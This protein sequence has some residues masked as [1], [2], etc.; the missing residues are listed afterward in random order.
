MSGQAADNRLLA[1]F[2][3]HPTAANLL[4]L[5]FLF[6]G[7]ISVG[8]ILRETFPDYSSSEVQISV[9]Y[10]GATAEEVEEAVCRRI[11]DAVDSVT[12]VSEVE[13][14]AR[15]GLAQVVV[16][17]SGQG[18]MTSFLNDIK[19]EVEAITDFPD[20][21]EAPTVKQ[22]N[23]TDLVCAVA[24]SGPMSVTD[25]ELYCEQLKKRMLRIPEVSQI[26]IEGFSD[27][28]LRVEVPVSALR[29]FGVSINDVADAI[30]RQSVNL[31]AGTLETSGRDV[32]VR[33]NDERGTVQGLEDLLV[34]SSGSGAELTLGDF[35]TITDS[36]ELDEDKI[37]FNGKR[38]G[39]LKINKIK[40]EDALD[41]MDQLRTFLDAERRAA[42]PGV[43]LTVTQNVSE[44]VRDRLSLLLLNGEQGFA[45]VF[46]V[47]WAFFSFR[48]SF[49][50]AM[51]MPASFAGA[52]FFM[53]QFGFS[54]NMLSMVGLLLALGL[55]MDDAIVI[56]ENVATHLQRGAS[57]LEAAVRGTSE[58]A[59][60]V[61]S[62][63]LTTVFIFGS[64]AVFIAGD[65]GKVLWVMPVVLLLTL[66][67]SLV[68]AFL[69]LPN[70][71]AH[72]LRAVQGKAPGRFRAWFDR[73]LDWARDRALGAVVDWAMSWR[74]LFVGLVIAVFLVS[75][76]MLAGGVLKTQ[77][78]P[79]VDGDVLMARI[80]LPQGTPLS[81]TENVVKLVTDALERVDKEFTPRQPKVDGKPS[82]LVK[83][84][85][86]QFNANP[87]AN[88]SG[89]HLAVVIADL[90][91]AQDRNARLDAVAELWRKEVGNV[92]DVINITYKQPQIGP[93]G[94]AID[95]RLQGEDLQRLKAASLELADW[96]GQYKGVKDLSDDL[97][98]GKPE[99]D[100]RVKE[101]ALALGLDAQTIAAQ[102]RGALYGK[103]A[104]EVQR[105]D[106]SYE[107]VVQ[108]ADEDQNSVAD[109]EYFHITTSED[110]LV[111]LYTVAEAAHT[112]GWARIAHV[113]GQ[114][115]VTIKGDVDTRQGNAD[116]IMAD[117]RQRFL[118]ELQ[119]RYPDLRISLEGQAKESA[120]T[121]GSLRKALLVGIFGIFVLLSFQFK[122]YI[123]PLVVIV[124]IP[125]A[126]IGVIWGHLLMGYP[127]TMPGI[128]GYVSL[129]GVVVNDS[130]LLVQFIKLRMGEGLDVSDAAR[131]ASRQRFRAIML[132]SLTTIAGLF[133]LMLERS[134][135]AQVLIPLAISI[136]F[137]LLASTVLVLLVVPALYTILADFGL[138]KRLTSQR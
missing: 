121:A 91:S 14:E 4:L 12:Y 36:F 43:S 92:P 99:V 15:E 118:P 41:I 89:P 2:A 138:T 49:W 76:S 125:L 96:L 101:G 114:R 83:N 62:S 100:L 63:F 71:L 39:L 26:T 20:E 113:N 108:L 65:I 61:L 42:P 70:H 31:P 30:A 52:L 87:D 18:E 80:L 134:L 67:V 40:S 137:G 53:H 50:V 82:H 32:L 124:A 74:Y 130:I 59:G 48:F 24:V 126:L 132:T 13:S 110:K 11:E 58:V 19:T 78:F 119:K 85:S 94:M 107:I 47:M 64:I 136:V 57:P 106:I 98:P 131:T 122:S 37:L 81:R 86:V 104:D 79:E 95:V 44:I 27:R 17:M 75:L 34:Y 115:T 90:L 22:L 128:M 8:G 7:A 3:S 25:L 23:K 112:R 129:A 84:V 16:T 38:A 66:S 9:V 6:L 88:E 123:E 1:Y 60:G 102:L 55:I 54:L 33:F 68:E 45:L 120:K 116:S 127:L 51:G 5:I 28:Q 72:S 111:P 46:L 77:A 117:T 105:G 21:A 109:L 97:R 135:Q 73:R 10:P 133:P 69:I 35:A 29:R 56:S 93:A 103:T